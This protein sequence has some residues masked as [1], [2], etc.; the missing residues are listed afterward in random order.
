M[1]DVYDCSM[2]FWYNSTCRHGPVPPSPDCPEVVC[3]EPAPKP[4]SNDIWLI[5]LLSILSLLSITLIGCSAHLSLQMYRSHRAQRRNRFDQV[6]IMEQLQ[7]ARQGAEQLERDFADMRDRFGMENPS[8]RDPNPDLETIEDAMRRQDEEAEQIEANRAE[9]RRLFEESQR[10]ARERSIRLRL[11]DAA[12]R[13]RIHVTS[14]MRNIRTSI[15]SARARLPMVN[16]R[17]QR[18]LQQQREEANSNH[19]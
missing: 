7:E 15:S 1:C 5:P 3:E 6:R 10:R 18:I 19:D 8:F 9:A 11:I 17:I 2:C 16:E 14:R 12:N 4:E 13:Q